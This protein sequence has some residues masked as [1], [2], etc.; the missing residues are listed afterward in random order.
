MP[1]GYTRW[2][3][4]MLLRLCSYGGTAQSNRSLTIGAALVASPAMWTPA[5]G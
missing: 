4:D 1:G 5:A 2:L 3:A